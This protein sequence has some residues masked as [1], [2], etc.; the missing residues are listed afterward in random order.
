[1]HLRVQR[2]EQIV[3]Q[4]Q[5][6]VLEAFQKHRVSDFHF[7]D[8][9]GYGYNDIGRE[10]LDAVYA[11]VFGAEAAIVRPHFVS[12][13]HAIATALFGVLRPGERMLSVTGTPYDTLCNVIGV[14]GEEA[15]N[16][17]RL[18]DRL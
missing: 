12:G 9:T 6:K 11:D 15:A 18:E 8:S 10:T 3:E 7:Q 16:A 17:G 13:T 14:N 2:I 5:W 4:N 1:M